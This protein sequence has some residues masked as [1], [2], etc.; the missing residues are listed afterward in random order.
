L[1]KWGGHELGVRSD[2]DF[3]F[4]VDDEPNENDYRL[5]RRLISRLSQPNRAGR[6][7]TVD[8]RLR[9]SGQSGPILAVRHKLLD[10]LRESAVAWERQAYT[11]ARLVG[12][13]SFSILPSLM[14]KKVVPEDLAELS[15]IRCK[16]LKPLN[17]SAPDL[18]LSPGGLVAIEFSSQI[19]ALKLQ[20]TS[21]PSD[22]LGMIAALAEHSPAWT[23]VAP[24][25]SQA[26]IHLRTLEQLY[27]LTSFRSGSVLQMNTEEAL[28]LVQL[29]KTTEE[30]LLAMV[31]NRLAQVE[32]WLDEVNPLK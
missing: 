12:E 21:L 23:A 18:K 29:L 8:L 4:L 10:Y 7:Y 30:D 15:R 11:R 17:A 1:G 25:L 2:L 20:L 5:A 24:R 6:L 9:P 19:A 32:L 3:V 26:Y 31:V 22:T 16:L 13:G 14:S 27:Q 28:R